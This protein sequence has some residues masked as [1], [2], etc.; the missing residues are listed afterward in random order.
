MST[1]ASPS[2]APVPV[3]GTVH[4][5]AAGDYRAEIAEVGA[6]LE[7][8]T[9]Q[10]RDLLVR[11][12]PTGPMQFYRGAVVAPWPNRI[13]DGLYTW[14]GQEIQ[15]ALNE[16]ERR[17]ALHGLVCFLPFTV[18][19]EAADALELRVLLPAS[20]GYPFSLELAVEHRVDAAAGLTTTV[21]AR[22]VGAE[23]APYGVCPHPYLVAGPE[24]LDTWTLQTGLGTV[25]TVT[26]DRLLPTGIK[27]VDEGGEFDFRAGRVIGDQQIDHAFTD[28]ERDPDGVARIR[29]TAPGGTGVEMSADAR[30]SWL[31]LHTADRPEPE[32]NRKGLAVEPMTCPPDAFRSGTDVIRLA[33]GAA[34]EAAWS[35]RGF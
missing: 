24:P 35:I 16:P 21:T 1:P 33:P 15:A 22:N 12:P 30:C 34:H 14:D 3:R 19:A 20:P 5:I 28:L 31:Q 27:R 2:A 18:A 9:Y 10:G 11:N 6:I 25:V 32:A 29:L 23:D 8:L 17:N 26:P 4:E 7:S 13:G